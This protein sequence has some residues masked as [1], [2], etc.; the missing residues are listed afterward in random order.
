M[1]RIEL[2]KEYKTLTEGLKLV[3]EALEKIEDGLCNYELHS[4]NYPTVP[5]SL[6]DVQDCP[7][8]YVF[9]A[10]CDTKKALELLKKEGK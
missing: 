10:M 3:I 1:T 5:T 2:S 8:W 4:P 9:N 7:S 6:D